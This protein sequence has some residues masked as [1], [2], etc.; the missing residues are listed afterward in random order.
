[1]TSSGFNRNSAED[2]KK[3][4]EDLLRKEIEELK[5]GVQDKMDFGDPED[6]KPNTH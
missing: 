3:W 4:E 5:I 1:M 6:G 2:L